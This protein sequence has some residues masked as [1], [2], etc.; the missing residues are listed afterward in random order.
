MT[1]KMTA[2]NT[3][4]Q[5][6]N[7]E[8]QADRHCL[9]LD[10]LP[11]EPIEKIRATFVLSSAQLASLL[12]VSRTRF[13]QWLSGELILEQTGLDRVAVLSGMADRFIVAQAFRPDCLFRMKVFEGHSLMAL[14]QA[15]EADEACA[16]RVTALLAEAALMEAAYRQSGVSDS[17]AKPT[18]A[19]RAYLSLPGQ[20]DS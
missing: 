10:G 3:D 6:R 13:Y 18:E 19:W 14:L 9:F 7:N 16:E 8:A 1:L 12:G 15:G 11:T 17:R 20:C 4:L 2:D 5:R